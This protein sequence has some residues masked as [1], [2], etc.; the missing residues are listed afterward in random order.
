MSFSVWNLQR[1]SSMNVR[2]ATNDDAPRV[3]ELVEETQKITG[4][5]WS[6]IYPYW[7][8]AEKDEIVGCLNIL[9]SKPLG[10]LELLSLDPKLGHYTRGRVAKALVYMGFGLLK[11]EGAD[12]VLC[13]VSFSQKS[14]KKIIKRRGGIVVG[15]GNLMVRSL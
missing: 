4:L 12:G 15:Q 6:D 2:F 7:L 3:K 9:M 5:D 8:V 13:I 1:N 14:F 10:R 11:A